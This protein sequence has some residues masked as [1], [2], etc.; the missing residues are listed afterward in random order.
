LSEFDTPCVS[1]AL[2]THGRLGVPA[3]I[4]RI[5]TTRRVAGR[6]VTMQLGPPSDAIPSVHLGASA[7]T[8]AQAGDIIVAAGGSSVC[9]AWGGLLAR[10]SRVAGVAGV[11]VDGLVRDVDEAADLDFPMFARGL[12][13]LTARRRQVEVSCQEPISIGGIEV[14]PGD[15]VLGDGTGVVFVAA[16]DIDWVLEA[17]QAI[18]DTEAAMAE[19]L[20]KGASPVDVLGRKY[21]SLVITGAVH[22]RAL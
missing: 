4:S 16:S 20:D 18:A 13:P 10:A 17:A 14:H 11:V 5:T 15:Y 2:E 3:G 21:E 7:I 9:A 12:S 6:V 8:A 22:H 1:D 19:R